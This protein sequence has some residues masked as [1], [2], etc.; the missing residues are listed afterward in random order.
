MTGCSSGLL[1][2]GDDDQEIYVYHA[3]QTIFSVPKSDDVLTTSF[4]FTI[5]LCARVY[6]TGLL[7]VLP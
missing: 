7:T 6:K 1:G 5:T 4:L 3:R 2:L